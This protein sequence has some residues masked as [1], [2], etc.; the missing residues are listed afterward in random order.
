MNNNYKT[1]NGYIEGY[2]GRLLNWEERNR[3]LLGLKRNKMNFYFY[4]PKEDKMHRLYW[5][6]K[7]NEDWNNQFRKF[8]NR[9]KLNNIKVIAGISPGIDFNFSE[10]KSKSIKNKNSKDFNILLKKVQLV[11]DNGANEI[12]LLFD[13]L[14]NNFKSIYGNL[15]SEGISHASLTNRL[16]LFL[17]KPIYVV[18][19]IYADELIF[20]DK[21]YLSD[22]GKTINK[23]N[24]TFYSGRNIV[25][26]K[27]NQ[28]TFYNFFANDYCPRRLFLGPFIGRSQI[29]NI[30]VNLTG[31][32]ETDLLILDI[33]KATKDSKNPILDWKITLNKNR[34][35]IEFLNICDYFLRPNFGEKPN[36]KKLVI[37][38]KNIISLDFLLWKWK[39]PLSREWFPYL[40]GLKHDLQIQMNDLA[41][42]RIIKTQTKPL[43][44]HILKY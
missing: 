27:I 6:K 12:A 32:I 38:K 37:T 4:A 13:D 42:T 29:N 30:M 31:L 19:R 3:I 21:R 18:P 16:S 43:A 44:N 23:D 33:I 41:S 34:I 25:S 22:F 7:Y 8:C 1:I 39:S 9:A 14:P 5:K 20:E 2:Y 10:F 17:N 40:L 26:K 36:L 35:P 15:I 11:L 24:V 28:V